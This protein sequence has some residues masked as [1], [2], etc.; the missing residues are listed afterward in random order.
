VLI[1]RLEDLEKAI[2][3]LE[4]N[5]AY[6]DTNVNNR[7]GTLETKTADIIPVNNDLLI[8]NNHATLITNSD[9]PQSVMPSGPIPPFVPSVL[10][11]TYLIIK[12]DEIRMGMTKT[13]E[14]SPSIGYI[15]FY[16]NP[17]EYNPDPPGIYIGSNYYIRMVVGNNE[18]SINGSAVNISNLNKVGISASNLGIR[19][20]WLEDNTK[21]VTIPWSYLIIYFYIK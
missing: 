3:N 21:T 12:E 14:A 19:F 16:R 2:E 20:T 5:P 17:F 8:I 13:D 10:D 6:D 15:N 7:L 9:T 18:L 11:A 4:N 1:P